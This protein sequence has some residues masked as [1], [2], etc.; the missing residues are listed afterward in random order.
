[1][2]KANVNHR[3]QGRL[4]VNTAGC[5]RI[6]REIRERVAGGTFDNLMRL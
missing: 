3:P 2:P 6:S 1:L 4:F 5:E